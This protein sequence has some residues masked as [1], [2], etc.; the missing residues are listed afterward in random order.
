MGLIDVSPFVCLSRLS[1]PGVC[2]FGSCRHPLSG[3]RKPDM[4]TSGLMVRIGTRL[5][6]VDSPDMHTL[7]MDGP[8][9]HTTV[10]DGPDMYTTGRG[11]LRL[12]WGP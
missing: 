2:I 11:G 9:R 4:H 8:D 12:H 5:E 6:G 3:L 10:V 1:G 7:V